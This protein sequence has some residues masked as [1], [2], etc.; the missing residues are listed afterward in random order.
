MPTTLPPITDTNDLASLLNSLKTG[1]DIFGSK[2][3]TETSSG[4]TVTE[5]TVLTPDAISA[6]IKQMLGGSQ[7]LAA[8]SGAQANSGLYNSTTNQQMVN[9][10]LARVAGNVAIAGAAK[11][12]TTS[13]SAVNKSTAP[14][15]SPGKAAA[16]LAAGMAAKAAKDALGDIF[17]SSKSDAAE[18]QSKLLSD[19]HDQLQEELGKSN[20]T[21]NNNIESIMQ[22]LMD[23]MPDIVMANTTDNAG[24][25]TGDSLDSTNQNLQDQ[26]LNTQPDINMSADTS[27]TDTSNTDSTDSTDSTATD[28]TDTT[29]SSSDSTDIGSLL[30]DAQDPTANCFITTA[31][32]QYMGK[33][34]N[35][36]EL[37]TLRAYRDGW[38]KE[39]RPAD[40]NTYYA[41]AP[42]LIEKLQASTGARSFFAGLYHS[43]ILPALIYISEGNDEA[44]YL[45]Y[46][47]MFEEVKEAANG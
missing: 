10:L 4:N 6:L 20:E 30:N 45:T 46:K 40:I 19:A 12:K 18:A 31:I 23:T 2:N 39:N 34:D 36:E 35:C 15:L 26:L 9:E 38:M 24:D 21:V 27:N 5:Q 13:G 3:S 33:D 14:A 28:N 43:H 44:A 37:Q 11:V 17:N 41:E 7:G 32:C 8:V 47:E 29:S 22:Q 42:A 16:G 1:T 25:V